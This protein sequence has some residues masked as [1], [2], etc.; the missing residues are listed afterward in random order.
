[1]PKLCHNWTFW[2]EGVR[3]SIC[4]NRFCYEGCCEVDFAVV[5]PMSAMIDV[6][7]LGGNGGNHSIV[8]LYF[9]ISC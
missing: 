7:T 2:P 8:F 9:N 1:M 6:K 4:N 5:I 3:Q